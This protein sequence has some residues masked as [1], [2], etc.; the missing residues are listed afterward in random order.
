MIKNYNRFLAVGYAKKWALSH[1]P[2]FY[3]F[4]R[5]GGDCTNFVSQCLL[6]GGALMNYEKIKGWFYISANNRSAS[7]TDVEFFEKFL[8]KNIG[9]GPFAKIA[10][11]EDLEVGDIIQLRQNYYR[12]NHSLIISKIEDDEIYVC[13]HS[14]DVLDFPLSRY[15]YI[16]RRGLHII[17]IREN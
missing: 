10:P 5:I 7:W 15:P 3:N 16:E 14:K 17:G 4:G 12:F 2:N 8:T 9:I 6:A 11:V 1:N 13:A